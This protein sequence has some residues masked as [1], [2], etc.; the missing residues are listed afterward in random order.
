MNE[1]PQNLSKAACEAD[2][3][4]FGM[5][6]RRFPARGGVCLALLWAFLC[7]ALPAFAAPSVTNVKFVQQPG[8]KLVS[9]TY[10]LAGGNAS[11]SLLDSS[12]DARPTTCPSSYCSPSQ[13]FSRRG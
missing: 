8:T 2:L 9:V 10:D 4:A 11:V 12:N 6:S 1:P 7:W 13:S 3:S 5:R